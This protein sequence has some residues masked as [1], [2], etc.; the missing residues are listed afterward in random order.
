MCAIV[1]K[2]VVHEVFGNSERPEAGK[3]FF[4]WLESRGRL[5]IG[6]KV[7]RELTQQLNF[8]EWSSQATQ[9][10]RAIEYSDE[11]IDELTE[12]LKQH[13]GCKSDDCHIIALAQIS[14]ARLLHSNDDK[15]RDD[16]RNKQI[17]NNPRGKIYNTSKPLRKHPDMDFKKYRPSHKKLLSDRKLC[18]R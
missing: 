2:N 18:Q 15:L 13:G 17:L 10:G 1:D 6:G 14:G 16:F 8:V 9:A 4:D 11:E 12:K 3:K 5:V 7:R